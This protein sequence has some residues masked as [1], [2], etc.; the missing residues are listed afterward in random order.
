MGRVVLK[1]FS[2]GEKEGKLV[3]VLQ[4][5]QKILCVNGANHA[6]PG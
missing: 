6:T 1:E 4:A 2:D 3:N 5:F